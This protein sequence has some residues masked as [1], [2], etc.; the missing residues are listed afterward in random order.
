MDSE[1]FENPWVMVK[2]GIEFCT[3]ND[4]Y[5]WP[6]FIEN[7]KLGIIVEE[8][9]AYEKCVYKIVDRKKWLLSKIKY[10]F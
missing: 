8:Y 2:L 10:S 9:I 6:D 5:H 1:F 7:K 3:N 4:M